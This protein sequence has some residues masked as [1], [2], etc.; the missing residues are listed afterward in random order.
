MRFS[1]RLIFSGAL[2][3]AVSD[4]FV[5]RSNNQRAFVPLTTEPNSSH[6]PLQPSPQVMH[7]VAL[8]AKKKKGNAK[9]AALDA[10]DNLEADL[11]APFSKKEEKALE[12][13]QKKEAAAAAAA[14]DRNGE[15]DVQA[16]TQANAK[17]N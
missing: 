10:L 3:C 9:S 15:D 6:T 4:A 16:P 14:A 5:P 17:P 2:L 12:K 13:Q 11:D 8:F 7:D 1:G